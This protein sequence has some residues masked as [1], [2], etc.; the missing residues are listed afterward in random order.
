MTNK[1][2][3]LRSTR[4]AQRGFSMIEVLVTMLIVS[5]A[6][7]GTSGLLTYA[8]RMNQGGQF[9]TQAVFLSSDLAE[10]MEANRATAIAGGYDITAPTSDVDC[11]TAY[12]TGDDLAASDLFKWRQAVVAALPQ[13]QA[14]PP[15]HV[16]VGSAHTYTI[17]IS[18]VDRQEKATQAA[19]SASSAVGAN[20]TGDGERFSYT[21]TRTF[22]N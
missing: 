5:L 11:T 1:T 20:S 17:T 13:G 21:A 8:M 22:Y 10:R 6:L 4:K 7:L 19:Y 3:P 12:C 2:F 9:R 14:S 16:A 18:W 15:V